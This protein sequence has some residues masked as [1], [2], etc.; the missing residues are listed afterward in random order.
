MADST[1]KI[2]LPDI[3]TFYVQYREDF[4][5]YAKRHAVS[6]EDIQDIYQ[7]AVIALYENVHQGRLKEMTSSVKTYLFSI[8]KYLMLN[9]IRKAKRTQYLDDQELM[10]VTSEMESS[11][12]ELT[13]KQEVMLDMFK[14]LS[15]GCQEIL[16]LYFYRRFSIEAIVHHLGYKNENTVKAHKSRCQKK[17]REL[18]LKRLDKL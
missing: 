18:C 2:E 5:A 12:I 8:G 15:E 10:D 13:D 3:D 6:I 7:D 17:L 9:K 16:H 14:E 4:F 1:G 11:H